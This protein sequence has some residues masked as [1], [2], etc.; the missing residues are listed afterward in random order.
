MLQN[1][2]FQPL[3]WNKPAIILLPC[4]V[5]DCQMF[6]KKTIW[7]I[8]ETTHIKKNPKRF[9]IVSDSYVSYWSIGLLQAFH[10]TL[11]CLLLYLSV[12]KTRPL[13]K[14]SS[15]CVNIPCS[16]NRSFSSQAE[17]ASIAGFRACVQCGK[18]RLLTL[19]MQ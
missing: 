11:C 19:C 4:W 8:Y 10:G 17:L 7:Q 12:S 16:Y 15:M 5:Y 14:D 2:N 18:N 9:S 13:G 3:D 1:H 6:F